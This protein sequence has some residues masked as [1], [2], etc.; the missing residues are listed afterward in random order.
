MKQKATEL[1]QTLQQLRQTQNQLVES[2]KMAALGGLVAGVAHEINTPLGLGV[3]AASLLADKITDFVETYKTGQMK[4]SELEG[5]L[6][7][8]MQNSTMILSNLN[9]AA[10][11]IASFK[12]VAVDQTSEAQR[13]FKIME[14][15]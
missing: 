13:S 6:N 7:N 12:Q 5:F 3:T 11:L 4:R 14:Y 9:R 15:L 2:E 1:E 8:I 10:D